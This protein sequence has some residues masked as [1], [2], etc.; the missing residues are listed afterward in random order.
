MASGQDAKTMLR[1]AKLELANVEIRIRELEELVALRQRLLGRIEALEEL[2][3]ATAATSRSR[4][5]IEHRT[6]QALATLTRLGEPTPFN[7][8][9]RALQRDHGEHWT[10]NHLTTVLRDPRVAKVGEGRRRRYSLPTDGPL[11]GSE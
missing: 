11:S 6:H 7:E 4:D 10:K 1:K 5:A 3:G 9:L 2:V 8:L